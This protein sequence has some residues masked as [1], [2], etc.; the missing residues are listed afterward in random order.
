MKKNG[1]KKVWVPVIALCSAGLLVG[2]GF[3][4]WTISWNEKGTAPGNREADTVSDTHIS[5]KNVK[6]FKGGTE[7]G[8]NPTVTFGYTEKKVG[9]VS[10]SWLT[11]TDEKFK[12]DRSFSLCF[13][14]EKGTNITNDLNVSVSREVTDNTEKAFA[15]CVE[16]ALIVAPGTDDNTH[17]KYTLS[18]GRPTSKGNNV[19]SYVCDV[20]FKWGAHFTL[21]GASV[22]P[23]S[24]YNN[25]DSTSW[26]EFIKGKNG[27][28]QSMYQDFTESMGKVAKLK[29]E[30]DV[31][32]FKITIS[33]TEKQA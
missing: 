24:F 22:N 23:I 16:K 27:Y 7:L 21:N 14:V 5:V 33:A 15:D 19:D 29:S 31:P 17:L 11:N 1:M 28:N 32:S 6:W 20:T 10:G 30:N 18:A 9:G 12:E 8:T 26:A 25:F 2:T 4:A 3:A 13:D